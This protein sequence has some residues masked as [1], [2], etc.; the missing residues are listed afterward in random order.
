VK[1]DVFPAKNYLA[2]RKPPSSAHAI[3][4]NRPPLPASSANSA[5]GSASRA[6]LPSFEEGIHFMNDPSLSPATRSPTVQ[7]LRADA[8]PTALMNFVEAASTLVGG[9]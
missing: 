9:R 3:S 7:Q 5:H 4:C 1:T 6:R 2:S 8:L